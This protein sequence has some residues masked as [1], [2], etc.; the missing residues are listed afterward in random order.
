MATTIGSRTTAGRSLPQ[1]SDLL[2]VQR[3]ST[4]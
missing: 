4:P 3:G 2:L 1:A